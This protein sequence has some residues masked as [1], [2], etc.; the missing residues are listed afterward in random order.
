[1]THSGASTIDITPKQPI[2]LAG[3][4]ERTHP[5]TAVSSPLEANTLRLDLDDSQKPFVRQ[6][7]YP[8]HWPEMAKGS[9]V[10]S[11]ESLTTPR[12]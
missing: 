11:K 10:L 6:F 1:M 8:L 3:W 7:R 9:R 12:P 4:S 2:P 5:F